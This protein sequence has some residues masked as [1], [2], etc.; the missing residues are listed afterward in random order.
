[1]TKS[2]R[3]HAGTPTPQSYIDR[4]DAIFEEARSNGIELVVLASAD[5]GGKLY[6]LNACTMSADAFLQFVGLNLL[7]DPLFRG[8]IQTVLLHNMAQKL[9]ADDKETTH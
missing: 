2:A 5:V 8:A 6:T 9:C 1:M 7:G 4:I 3:K